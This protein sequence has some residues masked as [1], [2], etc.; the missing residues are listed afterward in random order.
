MSDYVVDPAN[1][2]RHAA[3]ADQ[4]WQES[5]YADVVT[6]DGSLAAYIRLGLY[7]NLGAAWWHV[8]V[9]GPD[10]PLVVCQ[11]DDLP[12]PADGTA[13][14]TGD[15]DI[16]LAVDKELQSFTVRATMTGARHA[17]AAD[18]YDA[19]PGD[20]V[21]I[22]LDLTWVTDG[23]PF[24][25]AVTTRYEIPCTVTGTVTIDGEPL[26][27]DGPGQRDHSW[28]VRD[29]WSFGW[30]WSAGHLA[31]GTHTH[32][33]EV[34][35]DGGPFYAGYV[36]RDGSLTPVTGGSVTEEVGD[37]GLPARASVRHDDLVVAVE[38]IAFG[39]ILLTAPD[40]RV[41]RFP[42]AAA[43]FSAADGRAGLGWI[44]WNQPPTTQED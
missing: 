1:E 26:R 17:A 9:V 11:R 43:R 5:W 34:R 35:A 42:R 39:P 7:P 40:G 19:Q 38:P 22:E 14:S 41:G 25:Y 3:E 24:Q 18:V 37:H 33:T 15:V 31:D 6:P 2:V 8:A 32:L 13:I 4:L 10:R 21:R 28:G 30:S 36:Q 16:E 23:V 12:V 44:E 20:P 27:L 29:W